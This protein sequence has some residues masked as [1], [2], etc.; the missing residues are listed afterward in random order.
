MVWYTWYPCKLQGLSSFRFPIDHKLQSSIER[1]TAPLISNCVK[2][3][4][5]NSRMN[6]Y[7]YCFII[8]Y[9]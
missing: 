2:P 5:N 7:A 8:Y 1:K 9:N 6:E 3:Q 4:T